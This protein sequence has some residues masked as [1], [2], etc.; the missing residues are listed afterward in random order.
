MKNMKKRNVFVRGIFAAL[1][2]LVCTAC[3]QPTGNTT[4]NTTG[5][6]PGNT[7]GNTSVVFTS[8]TDFGTWLASKSDNTAAAAY[9][10]KLNVNSLGGSVSTEGS[11]GKI[12]STYDDVTTK[13]STRYVILDFSGSTI[14]SIDNQ[15]FQSCYGLTGVIIPSTVTSIEGSAFNR[16]YSL[17]SVTL[18]SSVTSLG[19]WAFGNNTN[20][21]SVTFQGMIPTADFH[22]VGVFLG[23]LRDKFYATNSTNGTP[24]TYKTTAPVSASSVWTKQ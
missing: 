21:T 10:V 11:V 2:A 6:S 19:D 9:T 8:I 24:G 20:L 4:G 15:A 5:N 12:L 22:N 17:T 13:T 16:C 1:I 23:D 14:T 3:N 7:P 18:P